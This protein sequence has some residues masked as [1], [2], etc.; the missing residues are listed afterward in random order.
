MFKEPAG[1]YCLN[2]AWKMRKLHGTKA[3]VLYLGEILR[4]RSWDIKTHVK[5]ENSLRIT[6]SIPNNARVPEN[7]TVQNLGP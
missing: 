6:G 1:L 4:T 5:P 3:I 2:S 7:H